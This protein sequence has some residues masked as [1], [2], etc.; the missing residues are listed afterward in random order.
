MRI[1]AG[2]IADDRG[3]G[4][5]V[6]LILAAPPPRGKV[7][8]VTIVVP[9]LIELRFRGGKAWHTLV[10]LDGR[11][12]RERRQRIVRRKTLHGALLLLQRML[13]VTAMVDIKIF[14]VRLAV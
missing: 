2:D 6:V 9:M 7:A 13:L 8:A 4:G 14:F 10:A 3:G 5:A 12:R 1:S 11:M